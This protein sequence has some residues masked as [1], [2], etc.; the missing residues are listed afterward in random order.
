MSRALGLTFRWPPGS[1]VKCECF[2]WDGVKIYWMSPRSSYGSLEMLFS[3]LFVVFG[4]AEHLPC[5]VKLNRGGRSRPFGKRVLGS[6]SSSKNEWAQAFNGDNRE[7]G[8][9]SSSFDTNSIASGGVL[10][11]KTWSTHP[12]QI[13]SHKKHCRTMSTELQSGLQRGVQG[14]SYQRE[15]V[16]LISNWLHKLR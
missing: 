10:A 7:E 11:R 8:V 4:R 3:H 14:R 6:R 16:K 1:A 15:P 12:K 2:V 13:Q 9:Y 5:S